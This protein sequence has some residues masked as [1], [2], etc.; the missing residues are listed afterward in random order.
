MSTPENLIT[1]C[2]SGFFWPA[3]D[4]RRGRYIFNPYDTTVPM[5][6][7]VV[8]DFGNLVPVAA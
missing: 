8:D 2:P 4:S 1:R 3:F 6:M 7:A 5:S